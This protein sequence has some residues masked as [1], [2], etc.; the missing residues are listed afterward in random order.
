[1]RFITNLLSKYL[2]FLQKFPQIFFAETEIFNPTHGF[3]K[4]DSEKRAI[5]AILCDG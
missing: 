4:L 5:V 1:M 3:K 2:I